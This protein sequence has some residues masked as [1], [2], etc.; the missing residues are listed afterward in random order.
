MLPDFAEPASLLC[1]LCAE[2]SF[3]DGD[4]DAVTLPCLG[5]KGLD[6]GDPLGAYADGFEV[7]EGLGAFVAPGE[8]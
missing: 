3:S 1:G 7:D 5:K 6:S 4:G 8:M 2:V